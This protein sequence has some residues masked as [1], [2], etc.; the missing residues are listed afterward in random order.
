MRARS[1]VWRLLKNNWA[2]LGLPQRRVPIS[3]LDVHVRAQLDEL[4][5]CAAAKKARGFAPPPLL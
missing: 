3:V 4:L 2:N 5:A 1:G